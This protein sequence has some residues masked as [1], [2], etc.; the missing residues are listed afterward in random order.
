MYK[1]IIADDEEA[2]RSRLL[3]LLNNE[4]DTFEVKG[5][6]Q[7]GYDILEE[8]DSLSDVDILITDIKMPFVSGL[9]LAKELKETYPLIQ[10]IFLSGFDDFDFAK[11]AIQLD[12]VAYLSKPLSFAELREAL[13]KAKDRL[14]ATNRLDSDIKKA[15]E[16]NDALL[17]AEQCTDL[18]KLTTIKDLPKSFEE[19]LK[20]DGD[21]GNIIFNNLGKITFTSFGYSSL[22]NSSFPL[23]L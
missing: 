12:A 8:I 10:I 15:R 7:N 23:I 9:E 18:L 1:I 16:K 19:K 5:S 4:K 17:K 21:K 11:Q 22:N 20:I 14:D 6:Y 2:T 13:K 3:S